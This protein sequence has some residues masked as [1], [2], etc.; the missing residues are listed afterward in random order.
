MGSFNDLLLCAVNGHR[1]A[2]DDEHAVN[3]PLPDLRDKIYLLA[4]AA[5]RV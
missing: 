4:K 5:T 2:P 1:V 3:A